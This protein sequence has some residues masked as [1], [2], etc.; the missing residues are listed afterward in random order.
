MNRKLFSLSMSFLFLSL[1]SCSSDNS[2][3]NPPTPTGLESSQFDIQFIATPTNQPDN[4]S[5]DYAIVSEDPN[6]DFLGKPVFGSYNYNGGTPDDPTDDVYW[7][8]RTV[9]FNNT[10]YTNQKWYAVVKNQTRV[11]LRLISPTNNELPNQIKIILYQHL[12]SF[13]TIS[14]YEVGHPKIEYQLQLNSSIQPYDL[15]E[16]IVGANA[17]EVTYKIHRNYNGEN[18]L[19]GDS[20]VLQGTVTQL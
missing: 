10:V 11:C 7:K 14:D 20:V 17:Q 3:E 4:P 1:T 18:V 5:I 16:F 2:D 13:T 8:F 12:N 15:I 6:S 9:Q 19:N